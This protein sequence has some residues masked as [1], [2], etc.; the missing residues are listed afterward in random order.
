MQKKMQAGNHGPWTWHP[1]AWAV[2]GVLALGAGNAQAQQDWD[3]GGTVELEA[4]WAEDY[5]GDSESDLNLATFELALEAR[6]NEWVSTRGVLLYEDEGPDSEVEVDEAVLSM[7]FPGG[8]GAYMDAGRQYV[9]FG[10]FDTGL[11]SDP[12]ALE[13]AETRETAA[14]LGWSGER[15]YGSVWAFAG[16][17]RDELSNGGANAGV[18]LPLGGG[19]LDLGVGYLTSL[20][21]SDSLQDLQAE[22][23]GPVDLADTSRVGAYNVYA[24]ARLGDLTLA[25]EYVA[26]DEAFESRQLAFDGQGAEPAAWGLEVGYRLEDLARPVTLSAAVQGSDEARALDLP[27]TRYLAGVSV[28]L[29]D[30][31]GLAFEYAHDEDYDRAD[32]GTGDSGQSAVVQLAAEF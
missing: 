9:P 25:G 30:R 28:E 31:L 27:E 6:L 2:G 19:G 24:T 17:T 8:S 15:V 1:L 16:D 5:A 26:A 29:M 23:L 20:G 21:D 7:V 22:N 10:R 3:W 32:G 12:L 4:G 14:V 18:L 13:L 11:V